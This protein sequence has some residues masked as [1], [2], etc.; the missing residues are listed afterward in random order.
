MV[1]S[2]SRLEGRLPQNN[3]PY[4]AANGNYYLELPGPSSATQTLEQCFLLNHL[5]FR[6]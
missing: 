2:A 3:R 6:F 4:N 1:E 5:L